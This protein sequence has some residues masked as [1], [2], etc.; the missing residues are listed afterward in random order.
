MNSRRRLL[1]A[2]AGC[3]A[4]HAAGPALAQ[5]RSPI[6]LLVGLS[7][8]GTVDIAARLVAERLSVELKRPVIVENR[9]GAG[10][11]VA[12]GEVRRS[13]P[14]G[15]TLLVVTD[16]PFALNPLI[17]SK[18][19]YR[20]EDFTPIAGV[21][22]FDI[23]LAVGPN[24]EQ[25]KD[26]KGFLEWARRNAPVPY[27]SPGAGTLPHFSGVALGQAA[28]VE[29]LHVPYKGGV[30]AVQ[31]LAAGQVPLVIS[32][33]VDM[34]ELHRAGRI[35]ILAV[36]SEE[37]SPALPGVPTMAEAG[38]NVTGRGRVGVYGPAGIPEPVAKQLSDALLKAVNDP[39]V[40]ERLLAAEV[41]PAPT[42]GPELAQ[43][44]RTEL[45][46]L[47]PIVKASG[48]RAD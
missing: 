15:R 4:V 29:M 11:R 45:E 17:Y 16:G 18:L 26:M 5:D 9:V 37:R 21:M 2:V 46:R 40:R 25:V 7:P 32:S 44:A 39:T 33:I 1:A 31:D 23:G 8:G 6:R 42:S 48:Y 36:A 13:A 12:L 10:Q 14:D 19:D 28:G 24:L 35:R 41:R 22:T 20:H 34:M 38:V 3:A 47:R 43:A 30:P 27:G